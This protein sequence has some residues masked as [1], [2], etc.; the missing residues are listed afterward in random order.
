VGKHEFPVLALK[1]HFATI[2]MAEALVGAAP[3]N[4]VKSALEAADAEGRPMLY[5][6][7]DD[8][9]MMLC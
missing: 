4:L 1:S 6:P 3:W 9:W 8:G 5:R 7:L 2:D